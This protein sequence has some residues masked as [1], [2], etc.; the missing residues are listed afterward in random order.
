M[1]V[2]IMRRAALALFAL[3]AGCAEDLPGFPPPSDQLHFPVSVAVDGAHLLIVSSNFDQR[4]NAGSVMALS[5]P[6]LAALAPSTAGDPAIARE[7]PPTGRSQIKISQFGGQILVVPRGNESEVYVASRRANRVTRARFSGGALDCSNGV[8]QGRVLGTDCTPARTIDVNALAVDIIAEDPFALAFVPSGGP[9]GTVVVGNLQFLSG[10]LGGGDIGFGTIGLIDPAVVDGNL[11]AEQNGTLTA[12]ATRNVLVAGLGGTTGF[13]VI[14]GTD[15]ILASSA[16]GVEDQAVVSRFGVVRTSSNGLTLLRQNDISVG[17]V[18]G[19]DGTRGVVASAGGTRAYA[20]VRLRQRSS[21][22]GR[23]A[24]I[25]NSAIA[26]ISLPDNRLIS[27][28][29]VGEELGGLALLERSTPNAAFQRLLY[30]AD[31]RSDR[32]FVLDATT[33]VPV[34]VH[35]IEPHLLGSTQRLIASPGQILILPEAARAQVDGRTLAFV[36]NFANSTLAVLDLGDPDPRKHRVV[37]RVG[38]ALSDDGTEE[39][40]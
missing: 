38:R 32:I 27:L 10:S 40:Q 21:I 4:Y 31:I 26:V 11:T 5:L 24:T 33:D 39:V 12:T 9:R 19:V 35:V 34:L 22:T 20:S 29:E 7:L 17:R 1:A 30:V 13:A 14:P 15:E 8:V 37:A 2:P 23:G 36:P 16:D 3:A 6:G 18:S 25:F 28:T